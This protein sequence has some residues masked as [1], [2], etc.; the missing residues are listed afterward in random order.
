MKYIWQTTKLINNV[1]LAYSAYFLMTYD[2]TS[3]PW[4]QGKNWYQIGNTICPE[5]SK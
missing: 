5:V 4:D 3:S 1:A 2:K